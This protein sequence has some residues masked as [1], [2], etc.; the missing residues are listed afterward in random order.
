MFSFNL[1]IDSGSAV[2][3]NVKYVNLVILGL[4]LI[5]GHFHHIF[6]KFA[7]SNTVKRVQNDHALLT[8]GCCSVLANYVKK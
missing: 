4:I 1:F 6:L 5:L 2:H 7:I 3:R 8:G